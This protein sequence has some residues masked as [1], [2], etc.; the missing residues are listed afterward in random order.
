MG[1]I[2]EVV[3]CIHV[4]IAKKL[5]CAAVKAVRACFGH[6]I[7]DRTSLSDIG[8]E[9]VGLNFELLDGINGRLDQFETGAAIDAG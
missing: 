2:I 4:G 8:T 7:D 9:V 6:N 1:G 5:E 3:L